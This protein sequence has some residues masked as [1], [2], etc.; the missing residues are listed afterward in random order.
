[1]KNEISLDELPH[2]PDTLCEG[3]RRILYTERTL[4]LPLSQCVTASY[5][6]DQLALDD[7]VQF[8]KEELHD[9]VVDQ[10]NVTVTINYKR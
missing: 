9:C 1:M 3:I 2:I 8:L 4:T 10:S 6:N 7:A 5:K